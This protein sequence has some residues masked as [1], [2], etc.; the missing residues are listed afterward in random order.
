MTARN[1]A[2]SRIGT[3]H[4]RP[5]IPQLI[6][7][8]SPKLPSLTL[9]KRQ[10]CDIEMLMSGAFSPL[11][12]FMDEETYKQVVRELRLPSGDVWPMP[13]TLDVSKA[14]AEKYN[15]GDQI[16]LRDEFFNL[17]AV[18]TVKD[19]YAPNKKEE[20]ERVFGTTDRSHPAVAYLFEQAGSVYIGG[21]LEGVTL[22]PHFDFNEIRFTPAEA[23][24]KFKEMGWG[25]FVAFQTRNPMHRAHIE[26]TRRAA[27]EIQ[28]RVFINP[29]VGMTKPG[30][31]DYATRVR[32]YLAVLKNSARYYGEVCAAPAV[33]SCRG[34]V[35]ADPL[36]GGGR[37]YVC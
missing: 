2:P 28:G 25:R 8:I 30:D 18:L 22:P 6:R 20:A 16:A 17:I 9:T 37:V 32:C 26:L 12:G 11:T 33:R 31:V 34:P 15:P 27:R 1:C 14:T 13:I 19:K 10:L 21:S 7:E 23:R 29:V 24:F 4:R 36:S 5:R 35:L 3:V